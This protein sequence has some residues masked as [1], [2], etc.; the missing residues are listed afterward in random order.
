MLVRFYV[1]KGSEGPPPNARELSTKGPGTD[2]AMRIAEV[3]EEEHMPVEII[4]VD[5][6]KGRDLAS[7]YDIISTP[8]IQVLRENG[9]IVKEWMPEEIP[10]SAGDVR[11]YLGLETTK[12]IDARF[13]ENSVVRKVINSKSKGK[14]K[15]ANK[16]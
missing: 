8:R 4:D 2:K 16:R 13:T 6:A 15:G 5:S 12:L 14:S 10:N 11:Y 1:R 7:V 3:L 9:S